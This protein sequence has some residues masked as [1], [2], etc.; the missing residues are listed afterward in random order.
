MQ[1]EKANDVTDEEI[2]LFCG[3]NPKPKNGTYGVYV[4]IH[5][6]G[7]VDRHTGPSTFDGEYLG[8]RDNIANQ[9]RALRNNA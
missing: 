2:R 6:N 8:M 7:Y 9:I 4:R 1:M 3:H 5:H